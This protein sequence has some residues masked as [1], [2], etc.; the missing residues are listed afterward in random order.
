[1]EKF[2][3]FLLPSVFDDEFVDRVNSGYPEGEMYGASC[4]SITVLRQNESKG[5]LLVDV[6]AAVPGGIALSA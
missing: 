4:S 2:Q 5:S 3:R 1:M 6:A